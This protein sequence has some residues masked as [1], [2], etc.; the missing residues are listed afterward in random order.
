MHSLIELLA[1]LSLLGTAHAFFG[2]LYEAT[3]YIPNMASFFESKVARGEPMFRR[4]SGSPVSYYVPVGGI[5]LALALG[6]AIT[7]EWEQAPG[8]GWF[9]LAAALWVLAAALTGYVV[10][11]INLGLFFRAQTD[12]TEVGRQLR[13]WTRLN[14]LRVVILGASGGACVHGLRALLVRG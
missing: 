6:T 8:H 5:A 1:W 7:S 9:A 4:K 12:L 14:F 11:R 10:A 3:V 13:R 2:N